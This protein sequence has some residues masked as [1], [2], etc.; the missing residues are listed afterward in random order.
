MNQA[1]ERDRHYWRRCR[2]QRLRLLVDG[3]DYFAAFHDAVQRARRSVLVL[4]WD[5]DSEIRLRRDDDAGDDPPVR[6]G[7]FL[8]RMAARRSGLHIHVLV[9]DFAMIYAL[10]RELLPVYKLQWRTHRRLQ[11]HM[12]DQHPVGASHHQKI[13]VIDDRLAFVGGLDL[14]RG[15]WDTSEHRPKDPRRIDSGETYPPFHDLQWVV[16]GEAAAALGEL[17][18]ERWYRATGRR[19]PEPQSDTADLWPAGCRPDCEQVAVHIARTEPAYENHPEVREIERQ[20][21]AAIDSARRSIYIENQYLSSAAIGDA[22]AERLAESEGPEVVMLLPR[23]SSGWLEQATM[24]VLRA[25]LLE[26]LRRADRHDRLRVYFPY[27]PGLGEDSLMVHGKL[28]CVDQDYLCI[29]SA[30]LSNRSMGLDT[31]CNLTLSAEDDPGLRRAIGAIRNRLLAEHLDRDIETVTA[32]IEREGSLKAAIESLRGAGRSLEPLDWRVPEALDRTVPD[33]A[34]IDPE[35]PMRSELVVRQLLPEGEQPAQ[36]DWPEWGLALGVLGGLLMLAG[37]WHWT[38]LGTWLDSEAL[39]GWIGRFADSPLGLPVALAAFVLAS[40]TAFPITVLIVV[41]AAVFGPVYGFCYALAGC[42]LGAAAGYGAGYW[43]GR[44]SVRRLAGRRLNRLSRQLTRRGVL[45]VAL[46]RNLPI[47]PFTV[48]NLVAGATR[49]RLRDYLLGT[50]LGMTPGL[51]ALTI[52]AGG[53][54]RVL[55]NPRPTTIAGVTGAVAAA[56]ALAWGFQRWLRRRRGAQSR[57]AQT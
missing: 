40:L 9:W 12:D 13:V 27:I 52:F 42:L 55:S 57:H 22:L 7:D 6:L 26:R 11:F 4:G 5:L 2:A 50:L 36:R 24:D 49:I 56:G 41:N 51:L 37:L 29:G 48:V 47:A 18:R 21:L 8:N 39:T 19:L 23:A 32:A 46:V 53:L 1:L 31:E 34:L 38:P 44:G 45:A 20:L 14:T 25:R 30:N 3:A 16:E 28:L 54:M 43:L 35:Q 33:A 10:E 15:R 17:A